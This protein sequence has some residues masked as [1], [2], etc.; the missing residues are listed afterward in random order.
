MRCEGKINLSGLRNRVV[1]A[2]FIFMMTG[3]S[4][5]FAAAMVIG[6]LS[7]GSGVY[8]QDNVQ[9]VYGGL[10]YSFGGN[11]AGV[12]GSSNAG[13]GVWTLTGNGYGV[14]ATSSSGGTAIYG[15]ALGGGYA[16]YFVGNVYIGG[17]LAKTTGSFVQPDAKDPS[18]EI[19]YAFFEG[20]EHAVFLRGTA[21][22][23]DGAAVIDTPEHFRTVAGEEGITV[24]FTPRSAKSK[25]L[26]AVAVTR[27]KIRIEELMGGTG[28]YDFDYFIT[29]KR[30]G[31]EKHEPVQPNKHFTADKT[32]REEFE[33]R[34]ARTDDMAVAAIRAMLVSNGILT[35]EGRLNPE[36]AEKLGWKLKDTNLAGTPTR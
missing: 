3:A 36:T 19:V 29:A 34:F 28:T 25:G 6:E 33:S 30:A 26:A 17:N 24:Q 35:P 9:G 23:I 13:M 2:M 14:K 8:Y 21:K 31:F 11:H 16:G 10:G 1:A 27:E 20:P 12:V 4:N 5:A 22:L 15:E 32:G 7:S 18:K